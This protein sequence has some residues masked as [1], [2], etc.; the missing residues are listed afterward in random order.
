MMRF[1]TASCGIILVKSM[2]ASPNRA[3][4]SSNS[5]TRFAPG[6]SR[7]FSAVASFQNASSNSSR[8]VLDFVILSSFVIRVSS[9][10]FI[11]SSFDIR[12]SSFISCSE[13]ENSRQH[14]VHHQHCQQ[15]LDDRSRC[16]L[17]NTLRAAFD[18]QPCVTRDCDDEPCENNAFDHS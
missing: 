2:T 9:L 14:R 18:S 13:K 16:C 4:R 6:S 1:V 10:S 17:T 12:A 7:I 11:P 8:G 5:Y 15:C 3:V